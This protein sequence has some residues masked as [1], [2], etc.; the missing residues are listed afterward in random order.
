MIRTSLINGVINLDSDFSKY[1]ESLSNPWVIEGFNVQDW[2]VKPWKARVKAE[3]T[4]GETIYCYVENTEDVSLSWND[5]KVYIV[6]DQEDID[7]GLVSEDW[8]NIARI[9]EGDVRPEKNFLKLGSIDSG[10]VT[11]ER[12]FITNVSELWSAVN[13]YGPATSGTDSYTVN[14]QGVTEYKVGNV[15]R[16]MADVDNEWNATLNING[17]W[18]VEIRKNHDQHLQSGDIEAG[19]IVE[20]AYDGTNF[21]M[22]SQIASVI[23][24][25]DISSLSYNDT[26]CYAWE[27]IHENDLIVTNGNSFNPDRTDES[28]D[29]WGQTVNKYAIWFIGNGESTDTFSIKTSVIEWFEPN[30]V[31]INIESD[32]NWKPSWTALATSSSLNAFKIRTDPTNT[33]SSSI[34]NLYAF[35]MNTLWEGEWKISYD[36]TNKVMSIS[37]RRYNYT[38]DLSSFFPN[39]TPWLHYKTR[40]D[41]YFIFYEAF[42]KFW[43]LYLPTPTTIDWATIQNIDSSIILNGTWLS[44][45]PTTL[46][47]LC[48]SDNWNY[49]FAYSH[50]VR[51]IFKIKLTTPFIVNTYDSF[52]ELT[53][54]N[55]PYNWNLSIINNFWKNYF[56]YTKYA[57]RWNQTYAQLCELDDNYTIISQNDTWKFPG[58]QIIPDYRATQTR[59]YG[60]DNE[61]L[62]WYDRDYNGVYKGTITTTTTFDSVKWEKYRLTIAPTIT[63]SVVDSV[64]I[65]DKE[66]EYCSECAV[67][68]TNNVWSNV[69]NR[70]PYIDSTCI[71]ARYARKEKKWDSFLNVCGW[72]ANGD[73]TELENVQYT[74]KGIKTWFTWLESDTAYYSIWDWGIATDWPWT[75][76]WKAVNDTSLL[77]DIDADRSWRN[78]NRTVSAA[79]SDSTI[80][81]IVEPI[82]N[83]EHIKIVGYGSIVVYSNWEELGGIRRNSLASNTII[84][85]LFAWDTLKIRYS[86]YSQSSDNYACS[87]TI[88]FF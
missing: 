34:S 82:M 37:W 79:S 20:V 5:G 85:P 2:V 77:V 32:D 49:M 78:E 69:A 13:N 27:E 42:S 3:R 61:L 65:Y 81:E 62:F 71:K 40:D 51:K 52:E 16:F 9:E 8:S 6:I 36:N 38:L 56:V 59:F 67:N 86:R 12:Y 55:S 88:T 15:Y 44:S 35:Y 10:D 80:Y 19:Q 75:Y 84:L 21:Q 47:G 63:W 25:D 76:V 22:D 60:G 33:T 14:I 48:I 39:N 31:T 53:L 29:V 73:F 7:S 58:T 70:T 28:T 30:S 11:D 72:F 50:S 1:I 83:N 54:G 43:L 4:N 66:G 24:L 18:A 64:K 74:F 46:Y 45:D 26:T 87:G 23:S 68:D 17:L 41:K 57:S